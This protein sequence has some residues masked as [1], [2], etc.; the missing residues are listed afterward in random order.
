MKRATILFCCLSALCGVIH[1]AEGTSAKPN[2]LFFLADDWGRN[3]SCYRDP[4]RPSVNDVIQTPN[5][6]RVAREG[7]LFP[8]A[9]MCVSSCTPSRASMATGCYFWRCGKKAFLGSRDAGWRGIHDPGDDLP[10]FGL[11]L[12]KE[13]WAMSRSG[14]TLDQRWYPGL[15]LPLGG[16]QLRFNGYAEQNKLTHDQTVKVFEEAVR[17]VMRKVLAKRKPGQPFCHVIGPVG[18][19]RP[20]TVG[21]GQSLWGINPDALKGKLPQFIPDVPEARTDYADTLGE[22]LA[23]DLEVGWILDELQKAGELDNTMLVLTGDNGI[24]M[25]RGKAHCYDL[26]VRAPLMIR[27]PRG[28]SKPGRVVD[29]FVNLMDLAPTWL[30]AAGI[31]PPATMDGRSL[32]PLLKS[33]KSGLI[34][35]TRDYVIVGRERHEANVRPDS[36]P[37]PMRA[38]RTADFLYIRNFKAERWPCGDP[39][40]DADSLGDPRPQ[41]SPAVAWLVAHRNEA[42]IKP[43]YDLC[44]G[45]RPA[46][47]LYDLRKDP[48]QMHNVA[49]EAAYADAKK[50]LSARLMAVLEKTHDPRLTDAFDK[51]PYVTEPGRARQGKKQEGEE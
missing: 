8:N 36:S 40:G 48:D 9:F 12:G 31:Q 2:I 21:S 37:Y 25:P 7:V 24:N 13:G 19:H 5:I 45:K 38:I 42:A 22:V 1:A 41:G 46:E 17:D 23:L 49:A 20:Y 35:P 28:I 39:Y 44:Y 18:P 34:D 6:D 11:L 51:P 30:E 4:A 26:S 47:E 43:L 3:A 27:W 32:L 14:K 15:G 33:E 29:D 10:G 16:R 50:Q